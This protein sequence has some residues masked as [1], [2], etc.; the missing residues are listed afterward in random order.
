M[1]SPW[2]CSRENKIQVLLLNLVSVEKQIFFV[3]NVCMFCW[4]NLNPNFFQITLNM[5]NIK[6]KK[7]M[8][9]KK[10]T[11]VKKGNMQ[12]NVF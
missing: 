9:P 2:S 12:S 5:G 1:L 8:L 3:V 7:L 4:D 6:N 10:E 11:L